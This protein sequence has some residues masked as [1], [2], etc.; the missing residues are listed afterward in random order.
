MKREEQS[1]A[2]PAKSEEVIVRYLLADVSEEESSQMEERLVHDP[3]FFDVVASVEDDLIMQFV[4]GDLESSKLSRFNEVYMNSPAKRARVESARAWRQAVRDAAGTRSPRAVNSGWLRFAT[5][6]A[7]A[8]VI[9]VAVLW[10]SPRKHPVPPP[11]ATPAQFTEKIS[12]A[13]FALEPGLT[14]SQGGTQISLPPGTT[15]VHFELAV[16]NASAHKS[17]TAV[18]GTPERPAAWT[19]SVSAKDGSLLAVVPAKVLRPGDYTLELRAGR[20][21]VATYAFR[22]AK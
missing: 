5:L 19:S 21:D 9:I 12:Y 18:L 2:S 20:E 15:E 3:S 8:V 10:W 1:V 22:V 6:A 7:A 16:A 17:Y 11:L 4:R 13:S 14:R